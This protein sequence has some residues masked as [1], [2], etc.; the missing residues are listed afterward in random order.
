M[1][2]KNPGNVLQNHC[3]EVPSLF[4][5]SYILLYFSPTLII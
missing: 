3:H 5:P 4:S 2:H 1:V